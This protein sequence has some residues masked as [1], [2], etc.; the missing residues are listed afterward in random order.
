[1]EDNIT[2]AWMEWQPDI[3]FISPLLNFRI[4][5]DLL[6]TAKPWKKVLKNWVSK[7]CYI[8]VFSLGNKSTYFLFISDGKQIIL[9]ECLSVHIRYKR[10]SI[11]PTVSICIST[12][13]F[14]KVKTVKNN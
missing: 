11:K 8:L 2:I 9:V 3:I 6:R 10:T 12:E 5:T 4:L 13:C 7:I 1:M 14:V